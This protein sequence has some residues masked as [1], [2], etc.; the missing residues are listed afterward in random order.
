MRSRCCKAPMRTSN[1]QEGTNFYICSKCD[2]ACDSMNPSSTQGVSDND[3]S[4]N[5]TNIKKPDSGA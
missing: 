3:T 5:A 1:G 2:M 4:S